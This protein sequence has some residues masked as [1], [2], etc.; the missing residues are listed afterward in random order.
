MYRVCDDVRLACQG[1]W[2]SGRGIDCLRQE[3]ACNVDHYLE[4][5][6]FAPQRP[7]P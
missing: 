1:A 6:P 4:S 2:F 5:A 7:V 3:G